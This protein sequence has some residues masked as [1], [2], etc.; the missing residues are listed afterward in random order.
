MAKYFFTIAY[1][2]LD[3]NGNSRYRVTGMR[4]SG[5]SIMYVTINKI[6][7]QDI[8]G[9]RWS[10]RTESVTTQQSVQQIKEKLDKH[11]PYNY[12]YALINGV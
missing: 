1:A 8:I 2:G 7:M 12:N 11:L 6:F 9:G 10:D 3:K 4:K 5:D